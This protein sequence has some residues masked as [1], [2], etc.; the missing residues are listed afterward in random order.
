MAPSRLPLDRLH[1]IGQ[2][3]PSR[4]LV[5]GTVGRICPLILGTWQNLPVSVGSTNMRPVPLA[6]NR[7]P[8]F[9]IFSF[10]PRKVVVRHDL[11]AMS[12][13]TLLHGLLCR[14]HHY[15]SGRDTT[16]R[17]VPLPMVDSQSPSRLAVAMCWLPLLLV[18]FVR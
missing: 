8:Q 10:L 17:H 15:I 13:E 2:L 4:R 14:F 16:Y 1:K 18:V 6:I 12:L 11:L 5:G 3:A 7:I 9:S